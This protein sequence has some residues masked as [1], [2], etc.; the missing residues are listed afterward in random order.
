MSNGQNLCQE[1]GE[2]FHQILKNLSH[3]ILSDRGL[4]DVADCLNSLYAKEFRHQHSE[5][6][7]F[8]LQ[9]KGK[10]DETSMFLAENF[11]YIEQIVSDDP[12]HRN[13]REKIK[14][15][16][17]HINLECIH[18][19]TIEQT[20]K[21]AEEK[22]EQLDEQIKQ[23]KKQIEKINTQAKKVEKQIEGQQNQHTIILGIFASI[24]LAFVGG[25]TFS[26][27][28]L[29]HMHEVSIHRLIF[30]ICCI[31]FLVS[32]IIFVM[33]DFILKI[34]GKENNRNLIFVVN[35]C[36]FLAM[37]IDVSHYFLR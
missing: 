33:F 14:R 24:V 12:K 29:S 19:Q 31:A 15:L 2:L 8:I 34:S 23:A 6:A 26:T 30:V 18:V 22:V 7:T 25:L 28:V 3:E 37:I 27:S 1:D 10:I 9:Y 11:K 20:E 5:I 13:I 4:R 16:S 21:Q 36:I 17:D 35:I 32:N